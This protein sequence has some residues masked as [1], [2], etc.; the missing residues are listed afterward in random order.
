MYIHTWKAVDVVGFRLDAGDDGMFVDWGRCAD[1][2]GTWDAIISADASWDD[3]VDDDDDADDDDDDDVPW[4]AAIIGTACP[5]TVIDADAWDEATICGAWFFKLAFLAAL[6][7]FLFSFLLLFFF[8]FL[9]TGIPL[10]LSLPFN[11]DEA[12]AD[13]TTVADAFPFTDASCFSFTNYKITKK[14]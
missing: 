13:A 5:T 8:V 9:N 12:A 7:A 3:A 2:A 10:P 11:D 1:A 4:D 14:H 6:A